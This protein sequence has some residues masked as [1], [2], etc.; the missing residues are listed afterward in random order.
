M[1]S[2][3]LFLVVLLRAAYQGEARRCGVQALLL[4]LRTI[5]RFFG[6]A[7]VPKCFDAA[8]RGVAI[9]APR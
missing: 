9:A 5:V 6:F 4:G 7:V 8:S 3:V 1:A 2:L